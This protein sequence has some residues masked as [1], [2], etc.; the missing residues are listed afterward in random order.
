M[1]WRRTTRRQRRPMSRV[2]KSTS[3]LVRRTTS[4]D[5]RKTLGT[6]RATTSAVQTSPQS[7]PT[8]LRARRHE[9]ARDGSRRSAETPHANA[10]THTSTGRRAE[11]RRSRG[12]VPRRSEKRW[13]RERDGARGYTRDRR[14]ETKRI[15]SAPQRSKTTYQDYS[16]TVPHT[17]PS[18]QSDCVAKRKRTMAQNGRT[19]EPRVTSR[20]ASFTTQ[21]A[22][23]AQ[24]ACQTTH[25]EH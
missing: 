14:W 8:S 21:A 13:S 17:P 25:L 19:H 18:L 5:R 23:R 4:Q 7:R 11:M 6:R 10:Q 15:V 9:V 22:I 12:S 2:E 16:T 1:E 3:E 20:P 24:Q